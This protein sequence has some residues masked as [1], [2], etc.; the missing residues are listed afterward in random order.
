MRLD[1]RSR[2]EIA[3]ALGRTMG[4][5]KAMAGR[6]AA[7]KVLVAESRWLTLLAAP[8]TNKALAGF[9]GVTVDGVKKARLRLRR[10]GF[11][12]LDSGQEQST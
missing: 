6:L 2:C 11:E 8:H 10:K 7:V 4:S 3:A 9:L 5:V 1:G 12:V